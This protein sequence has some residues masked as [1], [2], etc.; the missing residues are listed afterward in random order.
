MVTEGNKALARR[1]V[2]EG[3]TGDLTTLAGLVDVDVVDHQP[4]VGEESGLTGMRS[5]FALYRTAFPDWRVAIEDVITEGDKV[6]VRSAWRGTHNGPFLGIPPTDETFTASAIDI[7]RVADGRIVERWS[8]VNLLGILQ[9]LGVLPA[10][11][12][13]GA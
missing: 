7:V 11:E 3:T 10:T 13:P 2:E 12:P 9:Q 4:L 6:V 8:E 1:L 5:M